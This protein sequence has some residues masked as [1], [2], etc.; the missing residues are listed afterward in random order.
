MRII[1][2]GI[3]LPIALAGCMSAHQQ[4]P[5]QTVAVMP[6][7]AGA[8]PARFAGRRIT[9]AGEGTFILPDGAT[10]EADQSGGFVL[11]NGEYVRPDGTGG[12]IL[13]NGDRCGSDGARGY[14]C[15]RSGAG[16]NALA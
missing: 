12:V 1:W 11:P 15:L 13:P 3:T 10:V 14:V 2:F 6:S 9:Y 7:T 5:Q 16:M 8:P 4:Y